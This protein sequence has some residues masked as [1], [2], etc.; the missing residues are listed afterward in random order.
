MKRF[1]TTRT[2]AGLGMLT[3]MVVALQLLS[4]YV[5]FGPVSITLALF[6]IAVGAM[7]FGPI[8]GLFLGLVDGAM[9]LLAPSTI[10]VFFAVTPIGTIVVCL[11][12]TGLAGLFAGVVFRLLQKKNYK[13]GIVLASL[14]V[15]LI[16]TGLFVVAGFTVFKPILLDSVADTNISV[17]YMLFV[18][19]IGWNFFLE[20]GLN[21]AI[22]PAIFTSYRY[23]EK[24]VI[25][26][27]NMKETSYY[28][29][30]S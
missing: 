10:S 16:N 1:F 26:E 13:V 18:I 6:P 29:K 30:I 23:I 15:Q 17:P 24:K 7:L 5:Q 25:G 22:A 4:N 19:W 2:I 8:G 20:F 21:A 27:N 3:A 28:D 11:C 12:K 14:C 9:V